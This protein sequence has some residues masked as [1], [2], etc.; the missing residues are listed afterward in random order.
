MALR[1]NGSPQATS[2]AHVPAHVTGQYLARAHLN[3][4]QRARIA[5]DLANGTAAIFPLTIR[6]AAALARVPV[7]DVS[8]TRLNGK[9]RN[10]RTNGHAETLAEHIARSSAPERLDAARVIGPAELWDTMIS[11]VVSEE[12]AAVTP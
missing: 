10:G 6:Q 12:R 9:P 3:R 4:K 11:P 7:L 2:A 1:Y 5:G 8:R